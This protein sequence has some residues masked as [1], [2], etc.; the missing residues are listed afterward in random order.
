MPETSLN[1]RVQDVAQ[2]CQQVR[3]LLDSDPQSLAAIQA[4]L[5]LTK[6]Q[7][8]TVLQRLEE[9]REIFCL[10]GLWR[11]ASDDE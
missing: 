4:H 2:H 1:T 8:L 5:E 9:Q 10:A 7:T 3:S 11:L 6:P